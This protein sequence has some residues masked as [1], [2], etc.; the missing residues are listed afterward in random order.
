MRLNRL[1]F[2]R[3][4]H[5]SSI[6]TS[7]SIIHRTYSIMEYR[8]IRLCLFAVRTNWK[9]V[10][11]ADAI[12]IIHGSKLNWYDG[13]NF[14]DLSMIKKKNCN[15]NRLWVFF[16]LK[17]ENFYCNFSFE[18]ILELIETSNCAVVDRTLRLSDSWFITTVSVVL[19]VYEYFLND[20]IIKTNQ[21]I[22][23]T[24]LILRQ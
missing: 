13:C 17:F 19:Y 5:V 1:T 9:P 15:K 8:N 10:R 2:R 6:P 23:N 12:L 16:L 11:I 7:F 3:R 22:F 4:F 24:L 18:S 21:R 14:V 20:Y